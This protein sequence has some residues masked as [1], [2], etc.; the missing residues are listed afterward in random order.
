M[1][2]ELKNAAGE[3]LCSASGE[4]TVNLDVKEHTYEAGDVLVF[5][6]QQE[7]PMTV[8]VSPDETLREAELYVTG[9]SFTYVIPAGEEKLRFSP[10]AFAGSKHLASMRIPLKEEIHY[11]RNLALNPMDQ[12]D[13]EGVYP[14]VTATAET[15][16]EFVFHAR[17]VV[18]GITANQG[19]GE[20][21]YMSW[22]V[23]L[24][25]TAKMRVDFGRK[26]VTNLIAMRIRA[27]FPHDSFWTKAEVVFSD[28]SVLPW[29]LK[30][31][32]EEQ[33]LYFA[34]KETTF[35][36]LRNLIKSPDSS[37]F[38]ALSGL[39]VFGVTKE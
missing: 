12:H 3:V 24:D 35:I 26:I 6:T 23:N 11:P 2:I 38:P 37:T 5:D 9:S 1:K 30:K 19:H 16:G 28:G 7:K 18:D 8:M 10:N 31:T 14:H 13:I 17:N 32:G 27:D 25:P 29:E 36:E 22:G 20:W 33:L 34:D 39:R 15:R 4:K 21:P